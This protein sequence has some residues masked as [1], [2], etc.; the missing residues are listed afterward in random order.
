MYEFIYKIISLW[1]LNRSKIYLKFFEIQFKKKINN[2]ADY[3][4]S[5]L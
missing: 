3:L 4:Q 2:D 1:D 5:L